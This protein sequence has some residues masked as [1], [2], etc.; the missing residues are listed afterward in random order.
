MR[1]L[2][3]PLA[4]CR[5]AD[6]PMRDQRCSDTAFVAVLFIKSERRVAG[7]GPRTPKVHVGLLVAGRATT[8]LTEQAAF[9]RGTIVTQEEQQRVVQ[10]AALFQSGDQRADRLIQPVHDGG[11][12][13]HPVVK[14]VLL[15]WR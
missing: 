15:L 13:R 12:Q 11:V 2:C 8:K 4:V 7:V 5:D 9:V 3:T 10:R 1:G 6:G 14:I